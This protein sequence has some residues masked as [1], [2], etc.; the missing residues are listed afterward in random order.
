M[1]ISNWS[2]TTSDWLSVKNSWQGYLLSTGS[3]TTIFAAFLRIRK[4]ISGRHQLFWGSHQTPSILAT[5]TLSAMAPVCLQ[6]ASWLVFQHCHYWPL[7]T[8]M[9]RQFVPTQPTLPRQLNQ[10][11]MLDECDA[12]LQEHRI[13]RWYHP[14][15]SGKA[16]NQDLYHT[17]DS[18]CHAHWKSDTSA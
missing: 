7:L 17:M 14:E 16:L 5:P 1:R 15:D 2:E 11:D 3:Q 6:G 4:L 9:T 13:S 8:A 18:F 10:L 12:V